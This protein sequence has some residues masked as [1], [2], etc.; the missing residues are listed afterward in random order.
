MT[1]LQTEVDRI[2]SQL[3]PGWRV[4]VVERSREQI[5]KLIPGSLAVCDPLPERS[6]ATVYVLQP[7]PARESLA[8][9]LW[10]ELTHAALSP[11]T[12]QLG[13]HPHRQI[14]CRGCS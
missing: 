8:E 2:A 11:I 6:M 4:E 5:D 3:L 14:A 7:W 1:A 12:R 9:T 13:E 10:H